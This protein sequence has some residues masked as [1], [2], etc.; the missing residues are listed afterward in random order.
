ME[1]RHQPDFAVLNNQ[2]QFEGQFLDARPYGF[3]HINDTYVAR[4]QQPDGRIHRY[5]IQ[6]INHN[7]FKKPEDL[8]HNMELVTNH[9]RAKVIAAGGDPIRET[10]TLIPTN[11]GNS[12]CK[13]SS[14][15][16]WRVNEFIEGAQTYLKGEHLEHYYHAA[17]AFGRFLG[18]L[19][20]FPADRLYET[21]PDFHHTPKRFS[22]F[23]QA[24]EED[25]KNRAYSAQSEIDFVLHRAEEASILVDMLESGDMPQRVIHNDTKIDNVMID[26]KSGEGICVIDLDTVMPGLVVF[27][28]GDSVRSG[29]NPAAEDEQD[30]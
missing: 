9:M 1:K 22:S 11:D 14:G 15:D 5:I 13:S 21:I 19:S 20:D 3:G 28:F 29:A 4:F 7:V 2:F 27:D 12:F 26:K 6:R 10:V 23:V 16:Y 17:K 24:V 18:M 25:P 30:L 8:M